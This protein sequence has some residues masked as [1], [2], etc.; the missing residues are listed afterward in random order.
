[1]TLKTWFFILKKNEVFRATQLITFV[2][3]KVR[4]PYIMKSIDKNSLKTGQS[5]WTIDGTDPNN[6]RPGP[7]RQLH[8]GTVDSII[9]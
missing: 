2:V 7:K 4:P 1:M 9:I 3:L 8:I 5:A 6:T